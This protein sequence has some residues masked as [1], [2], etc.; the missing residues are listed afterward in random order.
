VEDSADV[1]GESVEAVL[2]ED[3]NVGDVPLIDTQSQN[4]EP[5]PARM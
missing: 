2:D 4:V 3:D 1:E 5:L